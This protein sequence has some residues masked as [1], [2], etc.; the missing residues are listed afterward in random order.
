VVA[1]RAVLAI[2]L[3][4]AVTACATSPGPSLPQA[5][6]PFGSPQ[7]TNRSDAPSPV[8]PP[9]ASPTPGGALTVKEAGAALLAA[10][11]RLNKA[12]GAIQDRFYLSAPCAWTTTR[13]TNTEMKAG[14]EYWAM[15][16]AV[17]GTYIKEL[18]AIR[19]PDIASVEANAHVSATSTF[20]DRALSASKATTLDSFNMRAAA[21]ADARDSTY[22]IQELKDVLGLPVGP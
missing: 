5:A 7:T 21:A 11:G 10:E 1:Y 19:F 13:C 12:W 22:G 9:S 4:A 14:K 6:T 15:V 18:K 2:T 16:A 17:L 20:R 8:A 3:G